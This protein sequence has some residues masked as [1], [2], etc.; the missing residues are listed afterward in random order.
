MSPLM[1]MS[2]AYTH[3]SPSCL[4]ILLT[5]ISHSPLYVSSHFS[6]VYSYP[7]SCLCHLFPSSFFFPSARYTHVF[8]SPLC[9]L[10]TLR[11]PPYT[12]IPPSCL[13]PLLTLISHSPVY[14][15][16]LFHIP[17]SCHCPLFTLISLPSWLYPLLTL[18][19]PLMSIP[20]PYT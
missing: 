1:S 19:F 13:S 4:P 20:L 17:L 11:S 6:S 7:A 5:L 9:N 10:F 15:S 18:M 8:P 3:I 12:H 14:L 16:S 2:P